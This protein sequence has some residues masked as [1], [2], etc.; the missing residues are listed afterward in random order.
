MKGTRRVA[1]G[2][3]AAIS[4]I[5]LGGCLS[6]GEADD[7]YGLFVVEHKQEVS[8]SGSVGDGPLAN[9]DLSVSAV[10]GNSLAEGKSD[11]KAGYSM[12]FYAPVKGYP[13][14][15]TASGGKDLVT[16]R[17]PDFA[18][19]GAV[20]SSSAVATANI[21]PFSTLAI[22]MAKDLN[23]GLTTANLARAEEVVTVALNSGLSTLVDSG[24]IATPI[25]ERNIAEIVMA[26]ETLSEIIRRSS[27]ALNSAGE[28][29]TAERVIESLGA[30][31]I[32]GVIEGNGGARADGRISAAVIAAS[33][34]VLL[35]S[36]SHTLHV[37]GI[38]ATDGMQ[39]AISV[40]SPNPAEPALST[41]TP[42]TEMVEQWKAALFAVAS[43]SDDPDILQLAAAAD[44]VV[45]GMAAADIRAMIS[46]SHRSALYQALNKIAAGPPSMVAA[47]NS[48]ARTGGGQIVTANRA[49]TISGSPQKSI[50]IGEQYDFQP[51]VS[52]LDGDELSFSVQGKPGWLKFETKTGRLS[53]APT[54]ADTGVHA[55]IIVSVSD[56]QASSNVGPFSITVAGADS[57]PRISG[58]PPADAIVGV[59]YQF[60]P[61]ASDPNGGPMRFSIENKPTWANFDVLTGLLA[62]TPG[63]SDVGADRNIRIS[64]TDGHS[65]AYLA[66]FS[67]EVK[68]AGK[69]AGRVTVSWT[70]PTRNEDGTVL[71]N[72]AGYRIYWRKEAATFNDSMMIGN[73]NVTHVQ[74]DDLVP[75]KYEIVVTAF[76]DLGTE[77]RFSNMVSKV[78]D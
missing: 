29:T 10:D 45:P 19:Q 65:T 35:E 26:S 16:N 51:K 42:G 68:S 21:N 40:V 17:A 71:K 23:G 77:S 58:S 3:I 8:I 33:A 46:D 55:G 49:P 73:A 2:M 36:M 1:Y 11:E 53:G 14:I 24:P 50:R 63:E 39:Y 47:V 15:I 22:E 13:L 4:S 12:T 66:A 54:N 60:K 44:G 64:V 7:P 30:D 34:Q 69:S 78:A 38:D 62:G 25:D 9:S 28:A 37:D 18:L 48:V 76:N 72:L 56:G 59:R 32:D 27:D 41:M 57:A 67:I 31:L 43:V 74:I 61:T 70:P 75:G 5:V 20:I 52:D 6:K